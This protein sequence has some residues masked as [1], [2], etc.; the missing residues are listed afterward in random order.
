ML[1]L[2]LAVLALWGLATGGSQG[3]GDARPVSPKPHAATSTASAVPGT[4]AAG[5]V[6]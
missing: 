2:V 1:V 5:G 4:G 6:R 3:Q